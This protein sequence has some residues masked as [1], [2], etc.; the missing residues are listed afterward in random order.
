MVAIWSGVFRVFGVDLRCSELDDGRRVIHADD[1]AKLIA[2]MEAGEVR[3]SE[4]DD[5]DAAA[6]GRWLRGG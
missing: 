3:G 4:A 1:M 2:A 5:R 6:I